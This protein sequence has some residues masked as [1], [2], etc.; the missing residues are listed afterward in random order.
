MHD[1][2]AITDD[3]CQR[4]ANGERIHKA[5][6]ANGIN[7]QTFWGWKDAETDEGRE[8]AARYARARS[9]SAEHYADKAVTAAEDATPETVQVARLQADTYK[10]RA[11]VSNPL[12]YGETVDVTTG[13]KAI[14]AVILMPPEA[15]VP[16]AQ[17]EVVTPQQLTGGDE[18]PS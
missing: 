17:Y 13:G 10:W 1:R 6:S 18:Q 11:K 8:I 7:W 9:L 12:A 3:I 14:S 16:L 15:P 4:V 2:L 5:C